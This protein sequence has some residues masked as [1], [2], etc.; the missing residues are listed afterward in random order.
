MSLAENKQAIRRLY[1]EVVD[2]ADFALADELIA[3][4]YRCYFP[5]SAPPMDREGLKRFI[6]AFHAAFP[7]GHHAL[8]DLIA[9]GDRVVARATARGTH[10]GEFLGIA[11]TGKTISLSIISIYRFKDG[12]IV[13]ERGEGDLFGTLTHLGAIAATAPTA[14][15]E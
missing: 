10:R 3:A 12:R 1:A 13:E 14:D 11:P 5:G 9:E 8:D 6:T 2:R 15:P 4:D 7:D